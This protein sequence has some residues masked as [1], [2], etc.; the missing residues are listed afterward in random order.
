M[1]PGPYILAHATETDHQTDG[2]TYRTLAYGYDTA[3]QA[4]DG[5]AAIAAQH[6]IA[7]SEIAV[8]RFIDVEEADR[9]LD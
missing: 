5:R 8:L 7:L 9:F 3:Q 4:L 6:R 1:I 2:L